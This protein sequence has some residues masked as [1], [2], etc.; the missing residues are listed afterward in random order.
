LN[1][2]A[3]SSINTI[4]KGLVLCACVAASACGAPPL[5]E[6]PHA[7]AAGVP[8]A[9]P[10]P[11]APAEASYRAARD[12]PAATSTP[13]PPAPAEPATPIPALHVDCTTRSAD[14]EGES[15]RGWHMGG[16]AGA[17]FNWQSS[18]L[19][20]TVEMNVHCPAIGRLRLTV[21][22]RKV[23][24]RR[25]P[26]SAGESTAITV[27]IPVKVWVA[28]LETDGP[29]GYERLQVVARLDA[30]CQE[31]QNTSGASIHLVDG[32]VGGFGGGE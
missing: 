21:G 32:F 6:A 13:P 7:S 11:A 22:S 26:I 24:D 8:V 15:L 30:V 20:C 5:A 25:A 9:A 12:E 18:V 10:A 28:A 19:A 23:A 3:T 27:E 17:S 4:V 2:L 14:H 29:F 31:E 16:P 1:H